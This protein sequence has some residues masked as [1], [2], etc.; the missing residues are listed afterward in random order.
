MFPPPPASLSA[1]R[2]AMVP[3][4]EAIDSVFSAV[5][6]CGPPRVLRVSLSSPSTLG[7]VLAEDVIAAAAVPP[8]A[9]S[10][11]DGFAARASDVARGGEFVVSG[12]YRA[13]ALPPPS[14]SSQAPPSQRLPL[15][16]VAWVTTGAPLPL[17]AD[18]VVP[19]EWSG[20][21]GV[22]RRQAL[23][24]EVGGGGVEAATATSAAAATAAAAA[25]GEMFVVLNPSAS[26][27]SVA[28]GHGVRPAGSDLPAGGLIA[29]TGTLL[30]AGTIA[31]LQSSLPPPRASAGARGGGP[32]G[33]VDGSLPPSEDGSFV[34]VYARPRVAILST[35]DELVAGHAEPLAVAAGAVA[36]AAP[37]ASALPAILAGG[38]QSVVDSNGPM[39]LSLARG[40]GADAAQC[41]F[42]LRDNW[43]STVRQLG[44]ILRHKSF[45]AKGDGDAAADARSST[46]F[47]D[48][49]VSFPSAPGSSAAPVAGFP[50]FGDDAVDGGDVDI[51]VT[52]GGVS[53]GDRDYV[54]PALEALECKVHFGRLLMKP[55][56]PAM[57]ASYDS[58]VDGDERDAALGVP[59]ATVKPQIFAAS[60]TRAGSGRSG[61]ESLLRRRLIFALPGNPV[62]AWVCYHLLVAPAIRYLLRGG[63]GGAAGGHISSVSAEA[64]L[65]VDDAAALWRACLPPVAP[66]T[67]LDSL[68]LDVERPE[69]HRA[70]VFLGGATAAAG[71]S[72][73]A[74]L[75]ARS[76]GDQ[77]SSRLASVIGAN[78]L[79]ALPAAAGE[80]RAPCTVDALLLGPILSVAQLPT[81]LRKR[82]LLAERD[83]GRIPP[84]ANGHCMCGGGGESSRVASA[85]A[86]S[87][88][89]SSSTLASQGARLASLHPSLS[90]DSETRRGNAVAAS[91]PPALDVNVCILT[92]SD[93]CHAGLAQDL[94]GPSIARILTA[95]DGSFARR[96]RLHIVERACAPDDE[97]AIR[98]VVERWARHEHLEVGAAEEDEDAS[99]PLPPARLR[100]RVP[101][102]AATAAG[103]PPLAMRTHLILTTGGT[104]FSARDVTPEALHPLIARPAPGL[105]HAM[106]SH[107][108]KQ[109]PLAALSRYEAGVVLPP[110]G[111]A[112]ILLVEMPG[113]PKAV[114]ECLEALAPLLTHALNL[115][116]GL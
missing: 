6:S 2:Y 100:P 22:R 80:L 28:P 63:G 75:C 56:K 19:V 29:T 54:K 24:S 72:A 89:A 61:G 37:S 73:R 33:G 25:E 57:F 108:L 3:M 98:A 115:I 7:L 36:S 74:G 14:A 64:S 81:A 69:Y 103:A 59:G 76:T 13:D 41:P 84:A 50:S 111:G 83:E 35:G 18:V 109:T 52:T 39:L 23:P 116:F 21:R 77:A 55:G 91:T 8:V 42:V 26:L 79:L 67:L 60:A 97:A 46:A 45:P 5:R 68:S 17:G 32:G 88:A 38:G 1:S 15:G 20:A 40:D 101:A 62:S 12:R 43:E 102:A 11:L 107:G 51:L 9:C 95:P 105:V 30:D 99:A 53:M 10:R 112:G 110:D 96:M 114:A 92:I 49:F 87:A 86:A 65:A 94:S 106:L 34:R 82:G 16:A 66:V 48:R 71:G 93:R 47:V 31:A 4:D 85:A 27:A 70:W 90:H 78:A 58:G 113:S 104:G 44:A